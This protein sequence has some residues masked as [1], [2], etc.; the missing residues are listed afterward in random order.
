MKIMSFALLSFVCIFNLTSFLACNGTSEVSPIKIGLATPLTGAEGPT[1]RD[2][3]DGALLAIEEANEAGGISGRKIK[4]IERDDKADAEEAINIARSF[5]LMPDLIA[6]VGHLNSDC[7]LAAA[8][9]YQKHSISMVVP[10]STSD[11]LT[12]SGYNNVFRIPIRNS[13]QAYSAAEWV[14][15]KGYRRIGVLDDG[16]AYGG[17]IASQFEK[18]V[19]PLIRPTGGA[20][21]L[22]SHFNKNETD[23]R[24]LL[25]RIA[26]K[27]PDIIY[28]G[29]MY[30]AAAL[31]LRQAT[32]LG[33]KFDFLGGDGIYGPKL[34][35]LAGD[36]AEGVTVT[37]IA[38]LPESDETAPPFYR[39]FESRFK[40]AP[41][42]YAPLGYDA[43]K[44][45]IEA[46]RRVKK[47]DR[48]AM[49]RELH[50]PNFSL[51]GV[52]GDIRFDETGESL[53]RAPY[54]YT[55]VDGKF[56]RT[57]FDA[58]SGGNR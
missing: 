45:V 32:E 47:V 28:F 48:E 37:F 54:F 43:A 3:R 46:L 30:P 22:R 25:A 36:S 9:I 14:S 44:V 57:D 51:A 58:L 49:R 19:T 18:T 1:G 31:F 16:G 34:I 53:Q 17:G 5:A 27:S 40:H 55:V 50:A 29:G 33:L 42:G 26:S 39:S 7:S 23:F 24:P 38:P 8:Q 2:M 20:V 12:E 52:T 41:I 4:L 11:N 21:V 15:K 35:E 13:E 6:V 10:V 56:R